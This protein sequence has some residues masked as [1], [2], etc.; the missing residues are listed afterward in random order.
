MQEVLRLVVVGVAESGGPWQVLVHHGQNLRVGRQ[1]LD[2]G[3]PTGLGSGAGGNLFGRRIA[4]GSQPLIGGGN[5]G[6]I[7][8]SGQNL[9]QKRVR[10]ESDGRDHLLQLLGIHALRWA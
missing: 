4:H 3:I 2:A 8:G 1:R 7:G 6:G 10:I 9:R 5:L